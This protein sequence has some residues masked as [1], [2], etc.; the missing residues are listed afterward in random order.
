M[1]FPASYKNEKIIVVLNNSSKEQ[2]AEIKT[3]QNT[4]WIDLLNGNIEYQ[5]NNSKLKISVPAKWGVI[6]K[7]F[8]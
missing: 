6:L 2:I 3:P 4:K 5:S 8:I 7:L 1:L